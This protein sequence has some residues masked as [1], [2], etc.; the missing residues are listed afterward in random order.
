MN[1]KKLKDAIENVTKHGWQVV[2]LRN[3][4]LTHIPEELFQFESIVSLDLGN[5]EFIDEHNANRITEIPDQISNFKNLS[6]L[7]L[8]NNH[9]ERISNQLAS[10]RKL[11]RLNLYNNKLKELPDQVASMTGLLELNISANPFELLPPEIAARG[12][13][14]IRH[15]YK[16]LKEQDFIY[17]VKLLI[18]GEGRVGKTCL[19]EA[20]IDDNYS[21]NDNKS[22]EG[23]NI[24]R[25]LIPKEEIKQINP[26]IERDFQINIWDFG[27]QEIYH[28]THQFFLTKRSIY[29]LV[30]E[31]RKEDSHDDFFYWLNI[32]QLLGDRSPVMMVLNKCDEPTKELPIKEYQSAFSNII[33]F[34]KVS[35][36]EDY[37]SDFNDFKIQLK[38]IASE[39]PH[40]GTPLPKVWVDIR[41]D[42]EKLKIA[43]RNFI[44]KSEYL[45]ICL[46][47]YRK[48][49]SALK[50]S[51]YFHDLG[52]IMH[53]QDDVVLKDIVILNHEWITKGVYK[54]LDDKAVID[55]KGHFS[56]D[57][58]TR[59]W[60]TKEHR[61][62]IP[63]L[64]SLMKNTKFDL[65]FEVSPGQ[66]LVPRLLPVDEVDHKWK[67]N[68]SNTR[69]EF[70]YK[71]MPKGILARLIV[72]MNSDIHDDSYWRYG[73]VLKYDETQAIVRERYFENKI[74]VELDGPDKREYLFMIRKTIHEIH[75]DYNKLNVSEMI[76]CSCSYCSE[77]IQP[78]FFE[79]NLLR[80]Y[81]A[82]KIDEIRCEI[83]LQNVSIYDLTA[84]LAR[85]SLSERKVF[86]CEN[87]NAELFSLLGL[88]K[89]D[90]FPERD[91]HSVFMAVKLNQDI[92]GI[93]DRD[94][95]LD[96]EI[97]RIT[98]KYRNYRILNYY[99]I[100]NYLY[101]PD[102]I[103]SLGLE[104][105]DK[106]DY[107]RDIVSQKNERK[108]KI[109]SNFKNA[110]KTYNEFKIEAE[111]LSVKSSEDD[112]MT[113][114]ESDEI[115]IF[116]KSFSLKDQFNKEYL[117]R[118]GLKESEL[119]ETKWFRNQIV[120]ILRLSN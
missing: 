62:K 23:I 25:W 67:S 43:G 100:E 44:S 77:S 71:F 84:D 37:R 87:K 6:K 33:S 120:D 10:L 59:I 28:S 115:E 35:L 42:L 109:I 95:L 105:F 4:G 61:D 99:C 66:Y 65:C 3:C 74:T 86:V 118:Y 47:H 73:V 101:H 108:N 14:S 103:D 27:G 69:F 102:N 48:E 49:E 110:R 78:H 85:K 107:A 36:H 92:Y 50:L 41:R 104:G 89:V 58:I 11:K 1:D 52:V 29:L 93:R 8:E 98:K 64:I 119:A 76:P 57:D 22:T 38:K 72:K 81:E 40:I 68:P 60:N 39:L 31:S 18:V 20:L 5:D 7:N 114:L 80:R 26:S 51:E 70:R 90:F 83:S 94:F 13:E 46:Q 54:V 15:F 97:E 9:V 117:K 106:S 30:T 2:N 24:E 63:E 56:N 34:N 91:S 79:F 116:F 32:I 75:K 19:S 45:E 55:Q 96:E 16:E 21:L 88:S 111:K 113:Y 112:I 53:F 82:N 12:I 17:E